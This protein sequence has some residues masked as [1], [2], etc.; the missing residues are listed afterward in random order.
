[1]PF[2]TIAA[3]IAFQTPLPSN[4]LDMDAFIKSELESDKK[5]DF[6]DDEALCKFGA[7][8][9]DKGEACVR[10]G[11]STAG[12]KSGGVDAYGKIDRGTFERCKKKWDIVNGKYEFEVICE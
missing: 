1:M 7:P 10:A 12:A 9:R 5:K 3:S 8:G 6:T 11:L 2:A 4:A